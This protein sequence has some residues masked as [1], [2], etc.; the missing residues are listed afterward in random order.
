MLLKLHHLASNIHLRFSAMTTSNSF[1]SIPELLLAHGVRNSIAVLGMSYHTI[2]ARMKD[3]SGW[4]LAEVEK[5]AKMANT[6]FLTIAALAKKQMDNPIEVPVSA[7][8]R[9]ANKH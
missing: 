2:S 6:D 9:S 7:R 4:T 1:A 8:G 3:P 5:V